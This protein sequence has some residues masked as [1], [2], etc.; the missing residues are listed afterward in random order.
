MIKLSAEKVAVAVSMGELLAHHFYKMSMAA[1]IAKG[2]VAALKGGT[3][4]AKAAP[5]ASA[6]KGIATAAPA[7]AAKAISTG[8]TTAAGHLGMPVPARAMPGKQLQPGG[9][10][11]GP[12]SA[13]P[14]PRA[15]PSYGGGYPVR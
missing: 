3:A 12:Y 5:V 11:Y 7:R 6:V 1:Q 4:A 13:P 8:S 15:A 10:M 9:S 14:A 2:G